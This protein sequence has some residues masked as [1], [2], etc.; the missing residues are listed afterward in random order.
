MGVLLSEIDI[1][2]KLVEFVSKVISTMLCDWGETLKHKHYINRVTLTKHKMLYTKQKS[3]S[4]LSELSNE[5]VCI[6][7][8]QGVIQ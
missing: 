8:V 4:P 6:L 3:T 2:N 7:V 5:I 1:V